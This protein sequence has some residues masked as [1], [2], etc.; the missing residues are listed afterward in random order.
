MKSITSTTSESIAVG[1]I[2]QGLREKR[3]DEKHQRGGACVEP[4]QVREPEAVLGK[5]SRAYPV[6]EGVGEV[7]DTHHDRITQRLTA[8]RCPTRRVAARRS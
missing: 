6:G 2:H 1:F 4:D 5:E 3:N 8:T 7:P